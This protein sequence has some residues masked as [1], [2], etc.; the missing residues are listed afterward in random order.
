[1]TPQ[2]SGIVTRSPSGASQSEAGRNDPAA[3]TEL[4]GR[5]INLIDREN[6]IA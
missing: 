1:L 6:S 5:A 4:A 3:E 2:A